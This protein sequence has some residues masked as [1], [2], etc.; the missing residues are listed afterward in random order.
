[1]T[2][3]AQLMQ[4]SSCTRGIQS[5]SR[6]SHNCVAFVI[7]DSTL[8]HGNAFTILAAFHPFVIFILTES[9]LSTFCGENTHHCYIDICLLCTYNL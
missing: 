8:S 3:F 5:R 6:N 9:M 1:M 7:A 2:S 4:N